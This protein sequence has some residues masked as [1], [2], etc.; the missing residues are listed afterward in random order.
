MAQILKSFLQE[1]IDAAEWPNKKEEQKNGSRKRKPG[2]V[3][4]TDI[5]AFTTK[6]RL[7]K[8]L[9]ELGRGDL[10]E[11]IHD[12]DPPVK[13]IFL[14]LVRADMLSM[15]DTVLSGGFSDHDLPMELD[16][17][18]QNN[19]L[20]YTDAEKFQTRQWQFLSPVFG[21]EFKF[22]LQ[23]EVLLPL[24][25]KGQPIVSGFSL[26]YKVKVH[27]AHI[28]G[29]PTADS[30]IE[31]KLAM[32]EMDLRIPERKKCLL[33]EMKNLQSLR[34]LGHPNLIRPVAACTTEE[35]AFFFFPWADKGD[36]YSFW[37]DPANCKDKVV[38]WMLGQMVGLSDALELLA[39][40]N[41]RHSDLKPQNILVFPGG[42][43]IGTLKITDVGISKFHILA[44]TRRLDPTSAQ[45]F[46]MRYCPPEFGELDADKVNAY[47][48]GSHRQKLSRRFDIWSLGCV[49]L[50][51]LIWVKLG[52]TEYL[53][54]DRLM[55]SSQ[56]FYDR[57][58]STPESSN[59]KSV[60]TP[61]SSKYLVHETV[62][63]W[64]E[65]LEE[66]QGTPDDAVVQQ[67]LQLVKE[68]M[69]VF[70]CRERYTA[71]QA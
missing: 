4:D 41:C 2:F 33:R 45:H 3:P 24:T 59:A 13:K 53:D 7:Q 28:P 60:N 10:L 18:M 70:D 47:I 38:P 40:M 16:H 68:S 48:E 57:M 30:D 6:S 44:T 14:T 26:V 35:H 23:P 22:D 8:V 51:F 43:S 42:N 12:A 20:C 58:S 69:L 49:F 56:R 34:E 25:E 46:T 62:R 54:F 19:T 11:R 65:K 17:L 55:G 5:K 21:D 37:K 52:R 63:S 32:K 50:E 71:S 29:G 27:P 9:E 64:L 61:E 31:K 66:L 67:V 39:D 36:L 1:I 15:L